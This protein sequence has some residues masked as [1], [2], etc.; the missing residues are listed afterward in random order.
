MMRRSGVMGW[1]RMLRWRRRLDC[2][3][4]LE[5]SVCFVHQVQDVQGTRGVDCCMRILFAQT[6]M[7]EA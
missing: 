6:N 3:C 7:N 5:A 2:K 1:G 4:L